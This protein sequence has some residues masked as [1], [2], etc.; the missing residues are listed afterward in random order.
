MEMKKQKMMN[1]L[2]EVMRENEEIFEY[3]DE[4]IASSVYYTSLSYALR[5]LNG[6]NGIERAKKAEMNKWLEKETPAVHN[7]PVLDLD[8]ITRKLSNGKSSCDAFFYNVSLG[9]EEQHYLAELKNANK[10]TVLSL[11]KDTGKDSIYHKVNDS[12]QMIEKQLEFGGTTEHEEIIHHTHFFLVYAGKNDVPSRGTIEK[13]RKTRVSRDV[14]GKQQRAGR[15]SFDSEKKE[16]EVYEYF[17]QK[18]RN[19]GLESCNEA[20]FP[21]DALP[22]A[23]KIRKGGDKVR[24]FSMF[25]AQDFGK[26]LEAGFFTNWNWGNYQ[27]YFEKNQTGDMS[28]KQEDYG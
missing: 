5:A 1:V 11:I 2:N 22:R 16:L 3:P 23:K 6:M 26:I 27:Q 13:L 8:N 17:G 19:L 18:V 10:K 9:D 4:R 15:M 21:G 20:T 28:S 24:L 7:I 25:S 14:H 12:V